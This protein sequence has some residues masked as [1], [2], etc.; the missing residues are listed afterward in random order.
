MQETAITQWEVLL[1]YLP[2]I[3]SL[4]TRAAELEAGELPTCLVTCS[5]CC[6][7]QKTVLLVVQ[8][9]SI[10]TEGWHQDYLHR[11][12]YCGEN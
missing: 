9:V 6:Q 12:H 5:I 8:L 2:I 11:I 1:W 3:V 10:P 7:P 4:C